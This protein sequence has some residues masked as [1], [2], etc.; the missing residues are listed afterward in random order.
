MPHQNS[1]LHG[2]LKHI[3]WSTFDKLVEEHGSDKG[4]RR[5]STRS[6]LV[7]LLYGQLGAATSL[8]EIET[9]AA[10]HAARLYHVGARE[11]SR[12]TL[13]DANRLRSHEVFSKLFEAM[14]P[15]AGRSVR[16]DA[17]EAVRL[18]D[19]TTV[20][21]SRLAQWSRFSD[22]AHGAK[23]HIVFDPDADRPVYFEVTPSKT[24]SRRPRTSRS[25]RASPT[26]STWAT[27][28]SPGGRRSTAWTAAS[29][30]A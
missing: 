13:A 26:S 15:L 19:S 4:V 8:R 3:P 14:V 16:K 25:R 5:L 10:S 2:L 9:A 12:S 23:A 28:T 11:V 6:Q 30:P 21:L 22:K 18:I 29:S 20:K 1:V 27:T 7:A 17:G 24:T